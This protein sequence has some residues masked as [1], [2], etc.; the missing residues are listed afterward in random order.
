MNILLLTAVYP[1]PN[2][3]KI[4]QDTKAIHYFAR[5]W[6]KNGHVVEVLYLYLRPLSRM[7]L[8]SIKHIFVSKQSEYVIDDVNVTLFQRQL[9]IPHSNQLTNFQLNSFQKEY[10]MFLKRLGLKKFIPDVICVHFPMCFEGLRLSVPETCKSI[11]TFHTCD[12]LSLENMTNSLANDAFLG[13][14]NQICC[15]NQTISSYLHDHFGYDPFVV[16]SG[17]DEELID[18]SIIKD[19]K[20]EIMR[21]VFAGNLI[22]LKN[23]D[24]LIKSLSRVLF[25][26]RLTVI[27]DGSERKKL[28]KLV[29]ELKL[30]NKV[31]FVGR[32]TRVETIDEMRKSDVFVMV[33]KPETFGLVYLEAMAQG[34]VVVGSKGQGI[35]GV[36]K[37]GEN[38]FLVSPNNVDEL[39][40]TL[41]GISRMTNNK[42]TSLIYNAYQTACEMTDKKMAQKYLDIIQSN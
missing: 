34:C 8:S 5:E 6:K 30:E 15:R 29:K 1:S 20:S 22:P 2:E 13:Q 21:I 32:L 9:F 14:F 39:V 3:L 24:V 10:L 12:M 16:Y 4:P 36:I 40:N 31:R 33:S 7:T 25:P 23:V 27:G 11:A 28:E 37:N 17:I 18:S 38:G 35:D 42:I 19:K 41:N 26:W